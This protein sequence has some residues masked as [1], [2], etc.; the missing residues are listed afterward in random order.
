MP[1]GSEEIRHRFGHH[2][3]TVSQ[4]E[5]HEQI[6]EAYIAFAEFLDLALPDGRAKS[7]AFTNLQQSHMWAEFAINATTP[8]RENKSK[9]SPRG[10]GYTVT[11]HVDG[12]V[13]CELV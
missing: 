1:V 12:D 10:N 7:T 5:K 3:V 11:K 9:R 8:A 13:P 4:R 2:P 6:Q